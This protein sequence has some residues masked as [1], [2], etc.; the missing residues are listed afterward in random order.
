MRFTGVTVL[1]VENGLITGEIGLDDGLTALRQP[2]LISTG[3]TSSIP[4][5]LTKTGARTSSGHDR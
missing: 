5:H 3:P 2:G 1:K 4:G